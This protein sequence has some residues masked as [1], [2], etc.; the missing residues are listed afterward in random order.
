[1]AENLGSPIGRNGAWG[2]EDTE[3]MTLS[4][5]ERSSSRL[6]AKGLIR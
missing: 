2:S 5:G 1:M 4:A 3:A 6:A